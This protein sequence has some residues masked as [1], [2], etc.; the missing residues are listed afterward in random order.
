MEDQTLTIQSA[1]K[2]DSGFYICTA[3]NA[4]GFTQMGVQ[5]IVNVLPR[6]V[7]KPPAKVEVFLGQD[8]V[9]NCSAVGEPS[10]V[11]TWKRCKDELPRDRSKVTNER[12]E[13]K[14]VTSK[15]SDV[16]S[17]VATSSPVKVATDVELSVK[18]G[19]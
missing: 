13:L 12:L 5:L 10:P 11:I 9:F 6:F 3:S 1:K 8:V 14:H 16:Y 2:G 15:D 4:L 18:I 19:K 7:V 17:C